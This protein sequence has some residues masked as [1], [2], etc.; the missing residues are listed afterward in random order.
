MKLFLGLDHSD[1]QDLF[2]AIGLYCD[3][4]RYTNVR[5][6]ETEDGI[7]VQGVPIRPDGSMATTHEA[8]L[9]TEDDLRALLKVAY[10]RR[11]RGRPQ[12]HGLG[13]DTANP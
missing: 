7:V 11:E 8:Y 10:E 6:F 9:F 5:V 2:R 1:Y 12:Q 4:H 3:E 13:G